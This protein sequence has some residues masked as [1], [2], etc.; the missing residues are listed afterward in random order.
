MT[1]N[2]SS[3]I[4]LNIFTYLEIKNII[5]LIELNYNWLSIVPMS[6]ELYLDILDNLNEKKWII[7]TIIHSNNINEII[8][9]RICKTHDNFDYVIFIIEN[10]KLNII[11][12]DIVN[13]FQY[14]Y[15]MGHLKII[16]YL[17]KN[18]TL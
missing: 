14:L 16:K 11:K 5:K 12:N 2:L 1:L 4:I 9:K 17:Y 18:I 8:I 10:L 3:D 7:P 15:R 6:T 13:I